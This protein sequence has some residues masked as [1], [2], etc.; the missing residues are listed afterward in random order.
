M[1]SHMHRYMLSW[2]HGWEGSLDQLSIL[3]NKGR[4]TKERKEKI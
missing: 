2:K 3:E 1:Q 4:F